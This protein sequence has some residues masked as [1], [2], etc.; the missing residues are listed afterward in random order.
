MEV[1]CACTSAIKIKLNNL[2]NLKEKKKEIKKNIHL[3]INYTKCFLPSIFDLHLL[4]H[5]FTLVFDFKYSLLFFKVKI[6]IIIK[7]KKN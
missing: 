1:S 3:M 4:F 6:Y 2:P 5:F 7:G